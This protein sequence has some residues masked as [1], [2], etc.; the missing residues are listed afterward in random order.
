MRAP[1]EPRDPPPPSRDA[2]A[3][4]PV[5]MGYKQMEPEPEA[6]PRARESVEVIG[7]RVRKDTMEAK[8]ALMVTSS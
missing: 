2:C 1:G 5:R 4:R 8:L 7:V 6:R 3:P